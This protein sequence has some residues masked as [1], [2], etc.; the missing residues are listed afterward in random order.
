MLMPSTTLLR[1]IRSLLPVAAA[2][3]GEQHHDPVLLPSATPAI[4]TVQQA[5]QQ[6]AHALTLLRNAA[7]QG[8]SGTAT[9]STAQSVWQGL[10]PT[11]RQAEAAMKHLRALPLPKTSAWIALTQSLTVVVLAA[12]MLT[13]GQLPPAL[14]PDSYTLLLRNAER[15]LDSLG[16]LYVQ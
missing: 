9:G 14:L 1:P 7:E 5:I 8:L 3:S 16:A 4:L 12:D 11:A 6:L 15:A 2:G 13:A 10:S